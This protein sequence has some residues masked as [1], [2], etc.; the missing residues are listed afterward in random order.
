VDLLT[1]LFLPLTLAVVFRRELF[2]HPAT[3]ALAGFGLFS[4]FD[5]FLGEPGLL[6]SLVTVVPVCLCILAAE[7]LYRGR[8]QYAPVVAA[9]VAS[10]LLLDIIDGGPVPLLYP[11]VERGLG[12]QYP[13]QTVFGAEPVG[14]S[15]Q[16]SLVSTR[17]AAPR[18]GYNTYGFL[19][20]DGIA[21]LLVFVVVYVGFRRQKRSEQS[22][23]AAAD[24]GEET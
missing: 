16:G 9:F 3:L 8:W 21:W 23:T 6:H 17:V 10:H 2:D 19:T 13:A 5:K 18:P 1:H 11:F 24:G 4:D 20:G 7:R 22:V 12:F 15:V 14:L